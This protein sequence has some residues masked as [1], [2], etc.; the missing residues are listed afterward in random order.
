MPPTRKKR[1]T[2]PQGQVIPVEPRDVSVVSV[3]SV[4]ESPVD[5]P[6]L[7]LVLSEPPVI[8]PPSSSLV[9][10]DPPVAPLL[11][12]TSPSRSK[13][14]RCDRGPPGLIGPQGPPGAI[15]PR[16]P[17]GLPGADGEQG[18]AG[19]AFNLKSFG[20]VSVV[21]QM[22]GKWTLRTTD[23]KEFSVQLSE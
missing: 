20:L 1:F 9:L 15:G 4:M 7:P 2:K 14:C 18:P 3:V 11:P 10:N 6:P 19:T 21:Y 22:N 13:S 16:G 5:P 23:D 17:R 12:P 8:L